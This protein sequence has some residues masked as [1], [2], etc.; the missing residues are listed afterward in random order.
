MMSSD[1]PSTVYRIRGSRSRDPAVAS[2]IC[3][4][5]ICI[6]NLHIKNIW[7]RVSLIHSDN[8]LNLADTKYN[9]ETCLH[10]PVQAP[11]EHVIEVRGLVRQIIA[12]TEV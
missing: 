10:E 2:P 7:A 6:S 9:P 3:V 4:V 8:P 11:S 5:Q 12:L 1:K